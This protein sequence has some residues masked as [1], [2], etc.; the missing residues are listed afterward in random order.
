MHLHIHVLKR[1][2]TQFYRAYGSKYNMGH[3][4]E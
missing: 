3:G 4:T 1:G 2:D